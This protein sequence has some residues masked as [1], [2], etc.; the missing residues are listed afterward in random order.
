[1]HAQLMR[2]S[3]YVCLYKVHGFRN[4]GPNIRAI[5]AKKSQMSGN[6]DKWFIYATFMEMNSQKPLVKALARIHNDPKPNYQPSVL[7]SIC[8]L[9]YWQRSETL[10]MQEWRS[11]LWVNE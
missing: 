1:M 2:I 7:F 11:D 6:V 10:G 9:H 8:R 3:I 5:F 4:P